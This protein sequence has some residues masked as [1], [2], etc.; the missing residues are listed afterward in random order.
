VADAQGRVTKLRDALHHYAAAISG[1]QSE[2]RFK[3][4]R[5]R[6][7]R[8]RDYSA[9]YH[10]MNK[11]AYER[12]YAEALAG[13]EPDDVSIR[14][15]GA[16]VRRFVDA[17]I[18]TLVYVIPINVEHMR[19]VG[20]LEGDGLQRSLDRLGE[21]VRA[22]GG[23]FVDFHDLLPD[24]Y[25]LDVR[26]HLTFDGETSGNAL[27]ARALAPMVLDQSGLVPR[28]PGAGD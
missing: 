2:Q 24:E 27:V 23:T 18:P 16:A 4:E 9:D 1:S 28:E 12:S 14:I 25:F 20:A 21:G 7:A 19:D 6:D 17:G 3:E 22:A 10:R 26:G 8:E 11:S 13:V 15:M 5:S